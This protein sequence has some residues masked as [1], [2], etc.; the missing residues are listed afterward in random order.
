MT[1]RTRAIKKKL[2]DG[3][4]T[5]KGFCYLGDRLSASGS[6]EI[7]AVMARARIGKIQTMW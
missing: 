6:S 1:A 3:V 5:V 2:C 7:P 4:E